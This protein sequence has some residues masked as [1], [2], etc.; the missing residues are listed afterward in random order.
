MFIICGFIH[1]K[2]IKKKLIEI[3]K[4]IHPFIVDNKYIL[5]AIRYYS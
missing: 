3:N 5:K 1:T 2:G 4:Y